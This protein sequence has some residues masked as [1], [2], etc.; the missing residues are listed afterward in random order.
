M[1]ISF[2][3]TSAI[4]LSI[5]T[6]FDHY[7]SHAFDKPSD[8]RRSPKESGDQYVFCLKEQRGEARQDSREGVLSLRK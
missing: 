6:S 4:P 2:F 5:K 8:L 1:S 3:G 7:F